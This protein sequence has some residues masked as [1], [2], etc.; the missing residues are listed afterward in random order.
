MMDGELTGD[1]VADAVDVRSTGDDDNF[2]HS[3]RVLDRVIVR[4]RGD[5][6]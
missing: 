6:D 3:A 2:W 4:T 1:G 5:E